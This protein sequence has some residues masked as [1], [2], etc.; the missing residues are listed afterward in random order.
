MLYAKSFCDDSNTLRAMSNAVHVC[1]LTNLPQTGARHL[2]L[3]ASLSVILK[4]DF[5]KL[6]ELQTVNTRP[7]NKA[8]V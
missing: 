2:F 4:T 8:D 1:E 5:C 7:I 3:E 6:V